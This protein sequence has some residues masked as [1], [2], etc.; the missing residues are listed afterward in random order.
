MV[1]KPGASVADRTR[2]VVENVG[3]HIVKMLSEFSEKGLLGTDGSA[4]IDVAGGGSELNFLMQYV[5]DV[6]GHT[7]HRL[8]AREAGARGAALAAW[9]STHSQPHA[10]ALN[11]DAPTKIFTSSNPERR[12]R[13]L[14]WQRM[15]QDVARNQIP[16]SAEVE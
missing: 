2:A 16:A 10:H 4:E 15:E 12:K 14:M 11:S 6:S 3:N 7:L 5:A 13:Y 1:C 8:P 9:M